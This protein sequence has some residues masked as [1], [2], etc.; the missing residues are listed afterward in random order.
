[1]IYQ[2]KNDKLQVEINSQG[3]ELWS[4][5][6][7]TG[8]EYLW[9]GEESTWKN[10]ATNLFPFCGRM[11]DGVYTYQGQSYPMEIHG[12]AKGME[13][14]AEGQKPDAVT[15]DITDNAETY[16]VYPFHFR[17]L[18][19]YELSGQTIK[20]SYIVE[21]KDD[22]TMYFAV[23]GH[24]GFQLP[25]DKGLSFEDYEISFTR[26]EVKQILLSPQYFMTREEVVCPAVKNGRMAL[27]H[28]LFDLDAL[29]LREM[30][31]EVLIRSE[32]AAAKIRVAFPD[33]TYLAIWH[34]PHTEAGFVCIEPWSSLPAEQ[35]VIED[36]EKKADLIAL[37]AG[38][39][40]QN[41]WDI[42]I[43]PE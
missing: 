22:K 5:K 39:A 1:M 41:H 17:F 12:F 2:I 3:A 6:D 25:I 16:A 37:S 4:I 9:Q 24:P 8:Q 38:K 28:D 15:L 20:Y 31:K 14:T 29:I 23:G 13:F 35:G 33:M 26:E 43:I 7:Q 42:E 34:R 11:T 10:R 21:N 19:R 32:K 18:V 36:L 40:Y 30:G 27:R